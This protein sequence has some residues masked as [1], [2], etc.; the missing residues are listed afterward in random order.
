M[1]AL[2]TVLALYKPAVPWGDIVLRLL[3]AALLAGAIGIE[4]EV[5][6]QPAG[7]TMW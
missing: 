5:S 2:V 7:L 3:A 4:R 6:G 1:T